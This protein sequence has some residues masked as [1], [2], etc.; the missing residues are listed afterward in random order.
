MSNRWKILIAEPDGFS[1]DAIRELAVVGDVV[2]RKLSQDELG[3]ALSDFDVVWVR[4][5]LRVRPEDIRNDVRCRYVVTATTGTDH[6]DLDAMREAGIKCVSLAG[7]DDFL[8]TVTSTSELTIGLILSL[9]RKIP[10]AIRSVATG[11]W[12]R[13]SFKGRELKSMTLGIVGYGRLGKSVAGYA[14]AFGMKV[15]WFDPHQC[16]S[17]L[18]E[19][20]ADLAG[21]L[22]ESD[23]VS[24]HVKLGD[25]TQNMCDAGFFAQMKR[26]AYFVNTSRGAVVDERALLSALEE[27]RIA[28]AALDVV[29]G[30]PNVDAEHHLVRYAIDN[31]NLIITPHIGGAS[32]DAMRNC[33]KYLSTYLSTCLKGLGLNA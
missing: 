1:R 17:E 25:E 5:N 4:L 21:V 10:A 19:Q 30:E 2:E 20:R 31:D 33:E 12:D 3:P 16:G 7:H 26:D 14:R 22:A 32:T 11:K 23:V 28:G 9:V 15:L 13:D 29:Q 8:K 27:G 18:S 6:L 24:I